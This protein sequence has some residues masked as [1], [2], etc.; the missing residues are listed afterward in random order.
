MVFSGQSLAPPRCANKSGRS[1][2][3]NGRRL[4]AEADMHA[5]CHTS[6]R[7]DGSLATMIASRFTEPSKASRAAARVRGA[8]ERSPQGERSRSEPRG[9][10]E[11][12]QGTEGA[13]GPLHPGHRP[14]VAIAV[15]LGAIVTGCFSYDSRWFEHEAEK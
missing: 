8:R 4:R 13:R 1:A 7:R 2:S 15:A 10:H 3:R 6:G 11:A 12:P 14:L 5:L 9:P